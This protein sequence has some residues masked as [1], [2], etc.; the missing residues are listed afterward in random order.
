MSNKREKQNKHFK[1]KNLIVLLKNMSFYI[2]IIILQC[3]YAFFHISTVKQ[4]LIEYVTLCQLGELQR[5]SRSGHLPKQ[6]VQFSLSHKL[7]PFVSP[8][9]QHK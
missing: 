4:E 5:Q 1:G 2:S 3:T 9:T 8:T 6:E 7:K